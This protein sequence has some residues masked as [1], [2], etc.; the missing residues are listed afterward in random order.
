[1]AIDHFS[2]RVMA[3]SSFK[4]QP[5]SVQIRTL[6]GRAFSEAAAV[7]QFWKCAAYSKWCRRHWIQPRFGAVGKQGSIAAVERFIKTLKD[8]GTRRCSLPVK[9]DTLQ[10][11]LKRFALRY[12]EHRPHTALEGGTPNER[13]HALAA[14]NEAPRFE[15]SARW[16]R[17]SPCA[18]P[19]TAVGEQHG[20]RVEIVVRFLGGRRHLPVVTLKRAA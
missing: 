5:T 7:K 3:L 6:L 16:P 19:Q 12:N 1:M 11:E 20:G 9:R 2:R 14:A 10:R 13:Y 17:S 18:G 15:P 8:E 4:T